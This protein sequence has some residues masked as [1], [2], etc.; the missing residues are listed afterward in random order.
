VKFF[1]DL[2]QTFGLLIY[3]LIS[4]NQG[5]EKSGSALNLKKISGPANLNCF[6]SSPPRKS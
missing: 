5:L 3:T 6:S 2:K 1:Q 4:G